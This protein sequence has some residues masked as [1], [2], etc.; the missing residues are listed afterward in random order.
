MHWTSENVQFVNNAITT[1]ANGYICSFIFYVMT[2]LWPKAKRSVPILE[3]AK[4]DIRYARDLIRGFFMDNGGKIEVN[5]MSDDEIIECI[6]VKLNAIA[7]SIDKKETEW[8][9]LTEIIDRINSYLQFIKSESEY[10]GLD[11]LRKLKDVDNYLHVSHTLLND[12]VIDYKRLEKDITDKEQKESIRKEK[13]NISIDDL[14]K[15][16]SSLKK[17]YISLDELHSKL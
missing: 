14:S 10:I 13:L 1:I 17:L 4:E 12:Y 11:N 16:A 6:S 15:L 3:I 2:I 8:L 7:Y 5:S 9:F